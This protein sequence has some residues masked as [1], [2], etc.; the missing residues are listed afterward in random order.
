[1]GS[2]KILALAALLLLAGCGT[3]PIA[4]LLPGVPASAHEERAEAPV[5]RVGSEWRYSDGYGLKVMKRDGALTTFQRLD[6]PSQWVVRRGFL[7][8]DA[9]SGTTLR[10]LL[11]EDLS[12]GAG[13]TLSSKAPLTYR[14]ETLGRQLHVIAY[15]TIPVSGAFFMMKW[16]PPSIREPLSWYPMPLILEQVRY[17]QFA[18]A[19]ADFVQPGYV[20]AWCGGL[21]LLGL[22][23]L[24]KARQ[25]I[26]GA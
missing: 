17:G 7:R 26:Y 3:M 8:E 9:Q 11:F 23:L 10:K 12:T 24:R 2:R 15:I 21:T 22:I 4:D 13:T 18:A 20:V 6:D 5:W 16:I 25:R 19:P 14:R 1:M